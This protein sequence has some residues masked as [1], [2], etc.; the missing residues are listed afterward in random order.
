MPTR[1]SPPAASARPTRREHRKPAIRHGTANPR[2]LAATLITRVIAHGES[3]SAVLPPALANLPDAGDRALVQ[4]LCYGVLRWQPRLQYFADR[5]LKRPMKSRDR[6]IECLIWVGLYQLEAM[7]IAKHAAVDETVGAAT[8]LDKPWAG[9]LINALLR[10]FLR[11]RDALSAAAD[12]VPAAHWAHPEWW[13]NRLRTDWPDDWQTLLTAN[14]AQAPMTLRV[15]RRQGSREHTLQQLARAGHHATINAHAPDAITLESPC[16][17]LQLPGFALGAVSVQDAAAQLACGLLDAQPGQR[18][19]DAC[20]AP[21]G[22]TAHLLEAADIDLVA[23]DRDATRLTRVR[24]TLDRL[25]LTARLIAA[26]ALQTRDWWDGRP[27]DRILLDAPCSASGVIRR[28][29]DIKLLRRA[30][31]IAALAA[32]QRALLAALWPLLAPGGMLLYVTCSVLAEE[33]RQNV[34]AFLD[35]HADARARPID[36]TW[37]RAAGPGRQI[38][39]G[40]SGMDGFYYALL[41][42]TVALA[43]SAPEPRNP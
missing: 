21:G 26:D 35:D 13:I 5:L 23:I 18:V 34:N 10:G 36:A 28:H 9:G 27:F 37:G 2:A 1:R 7:R 41:E 42:K 24:E 12:A 33:N 29:P 15:N 17:V 4:A 3:L 20:A 14:N 38:L 40:E 16:D 6:D 25:G 22:K 30:D 39:P 31:D 32:A 43:R 8:A 19:L 11:E